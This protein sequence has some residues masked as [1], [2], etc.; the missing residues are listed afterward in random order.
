MEVVYKKT[1]NGRIFQ[2]ENCNDIHLEYKILNLNLSL[3]QFHQ[4]SL[5]IIAIE[6]EKWV[7]R[8]NKSGMAR[9]IFIP[10]ENRNILLMLNLEEL[11][12]LKELVEQINI[13]NPEIDSVISFN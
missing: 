4:F 13:I 2:C 5:N 6:G 7:S 1:K 9:K 8:N 10:L 12:E 11:N 3:T